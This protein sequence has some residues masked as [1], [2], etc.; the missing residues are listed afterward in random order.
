MA[1]ST[2]AS[3][4]TLLPKPTPSPVDVPQRQG[5]GL[6]WFAVALVVAFTAALAT[7]A[8]TQSN[9]DSVVDT[10]TSAV[11]GQLSPNAA[12]YRDAQILWQQAE[13]S[14]GGTSPNAADYRDRQLQ[15]QSS[16]TTSGPISP[17]AADYRDAHIGG[18]VREP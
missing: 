4:T 5:R 11:T 3:G 16:P 9:N 18:G 1:S 14:T 7:W 2:T 10:S 6:F 17:N 8:I 15:Q 13:T 12:D